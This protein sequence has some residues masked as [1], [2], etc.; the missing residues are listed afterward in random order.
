MEAENRNSD[1]TES[2]AY[3]SVADRALCR[4]IHF[5]LWVYTFYN[6]DPKKMDREHWLCLY[7]LFCIKEGIPNK[8]IDERNKRNEKEA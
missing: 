8:F 6:I 1:F 7:R 2:N 5:Y 3:K 4:L